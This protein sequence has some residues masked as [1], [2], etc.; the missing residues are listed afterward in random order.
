MLCCEHERRTVKQDVLKV[1][2]R[3]DKAPEIYHTYILTS[4]RADFAVTCV[5]D[6]EPLEPLLKH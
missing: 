6:D 2:V 5:T 4:A 1:V 3:R